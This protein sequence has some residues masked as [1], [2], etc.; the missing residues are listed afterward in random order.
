MTAEDD[1]G[2]NTLHARPNVIHEVGLFQGKLGFRKAKILV[3]DGCED[4]SNITGLI[5]I[6]FPKGN[7][8]ASLEKIRQVLERENVIEK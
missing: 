5:Q 1:H 4:F 8:S 3:E 6:R 2:D 7:I